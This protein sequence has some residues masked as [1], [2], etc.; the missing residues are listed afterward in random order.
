I[1]DAYDNGYKVIDFFGTSGNPNPPKDNPIYGIHNF[2]K[3]LGGEYTEFIGEY[4]LII[5][6]FMYRLYNIVV[7]IRRKIV[8]A[9]LKKKVNNEKK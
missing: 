7:P 3:R 2:K 8:K 4:D 5:N 1:K 9:K 6:K